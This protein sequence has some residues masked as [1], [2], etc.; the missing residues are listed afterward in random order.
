MPTFVR[1]N[2]MHPH[3]ERRLEVRPA[4]RDYVT[5]LHERGQIRMSGPLAD[6]TGAIILYVADD[7]DAAR[8]LVEADPYAKAGVVQELSLR[9]WTVVTPADS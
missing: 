5:E 9:E 2:T 6:Q 8:A 1:E 3:D 4:H 7:L